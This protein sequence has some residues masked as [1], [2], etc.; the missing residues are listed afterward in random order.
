MIEQMTYRQ[1][2][3]DAL[4]TMESC[5]NNL[6]DVA[7]CL[8][9]FEDR[10]NGC[11]PFEEG[12]EIP[13]DMGLL[14][15]SDIPSVHVLEDTINELLDVHT[16]IYNVN[17]LSEDL[18]EDEERSGKDGNY[19]YDPF[20]M[21]P[22]KTM[23]DLRLEA[24]DFISYALADVMHSAYHL[25]YNRE[26]PDDF[27]H[28]FF[29]PSEGTYALLASDDANVKALLSLAKFLEQKRDDASLLAS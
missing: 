26:I 23:E 12:D 24:S 22:R 1:L 9:F 2:L 10:Q 14:E 3:L 21:N 4:A 6:G 27:E 25:L 7:L 18:P 29:F 19:S 20:P 8:I 17:N 11:F 13:L 16:Y 28:D 5:W 15:A